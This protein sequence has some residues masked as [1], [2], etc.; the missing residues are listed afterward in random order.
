[1]HLAEVHG[2]GQHFCFVRER[3][4][5][6]TTKPDFTDF[7]LQFYA[8]PLSEVQNFCCNM[9]TKKL[10]MVRSVISGISCDR[11]DV[12]QTVGIPVR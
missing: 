6:G 7:I 2:L 8:E 4:E 12:G 11:A 3:T 5:V 10:S 9:F 1:M